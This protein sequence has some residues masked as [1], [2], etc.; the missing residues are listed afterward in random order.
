MLIVA[1]GELDN[2][3]ATIWFHCTIHYHQYLL[4]LVVVFHLRSN[5][6]YIR[7][8]ACCHVPNGHSHHHRLCNQDCHHQI[9]K[10]NSRVC[11]FNE[12]I[13]Q[14]AWDH[15]SNNLQALKV[16]LNSPIIKDKMQAWCWTRWIIALHW[17]IMIKF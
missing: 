4:V 10:F 6:R 8:V 11:W 7:L 13:I 5:K 2:Y 14:C 1:H 3:L 17:W 15:W 16:D 9:V 12:F